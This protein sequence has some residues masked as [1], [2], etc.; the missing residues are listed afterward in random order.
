MSTS[1]KLLAVAGAAAMVVLTPGL[2][3][4]K[5]RPNT[6]RFTGGTNVSTLNVTCAKGATSGTT[7]QKLSVKATRKF[8][9]AVTEDFIG[10]SLGQSTKF[11]ASFPSP[12][13]KGGVGKLTL[14]RFESL[15]KINPSK[16]FRFPCPNTAVGG[17]ST[18]NITIQPYRGSKPI[19]T[20]AQV[21]V[22]LVRVGQGS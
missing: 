1:R 18:L 13:T 20:P 14:T 21:N 7:S 6:F 22:N 17:T 19:G 3:E 5:A 4:A 10:N 16:N 8:S 9:S 11:V 15:Y 12:G 2:A